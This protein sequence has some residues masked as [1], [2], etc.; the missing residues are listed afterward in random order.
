[1]NNVIQTSSEAVEGEDG[2]QASSSGPVGFIPDIVSDNK[3]VY[4][5]G[6]INF[7][8]YNGMLLQKSLTRLAQSTGASNLRLWG[9]ISGTEK[10]YYIAEGVAEIAAADDGQEKAADIETRGPQSS[11]NA[12]NY[13]VCNSPDDEKWHLLPD[14]EPKDIQAARQTKFNFTGDIERKIIT[15]P[16]FFKREKH[17]LRA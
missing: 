6:G 8:E 14:L 2:G 13:W 10:D 4:Q 12:F 11:V 15:N 3:N 9:K 7:G 5:W 1:M 17:L 16:F